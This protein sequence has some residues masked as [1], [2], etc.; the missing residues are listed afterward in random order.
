MVKFVNYDA[1]AAE[2]DRRY[3]K[4]DYSGVESV[5]LDFI[6]EDPSVH[7]LEVGCGTGHWLE[8]LSGRGYRVVGLDASRSMVNQAKSKIPHAALVHGHAE[9]L[10]WQAASFERIFCINAFHH[11]SDKTSFMTEARRVLRRGGSL[12]IIGLDPHT[13]CNRWWIYDYFP[14][15]VAMDKGRYPPTHELRKLMSESGFVDS[16]TVE[17]QHL[18]LHVPAHMALE[19]GRLDKT[20]TSQLALLTDD[21]YIDGIRRLQRDIETAEAHNEVLPLHTDLWL[22][23]TMGSVV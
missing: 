8:V 22:C 5:L 15:V 6:G 17:A 20:V 1:I 18:L 21:E 9:A 4:T 11:F 23:A 12:M 19:Q 3:D 14:Q 7:I 16:C 10:P 13:D 2:Y